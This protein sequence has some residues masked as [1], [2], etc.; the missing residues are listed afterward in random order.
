MTQPA[1][2]EAAPSTA[3]TPPT[4][5]A[6]TDTHAPLTTKALATQIREAAGVN[7]SDLRKLQRFSWLSLQGEV[8]WTWGGASPLSKDY[9]VLAM[10]DDVKEV[11]AYAAPTVPNAPYV[12]YKLNKDTPS[13]GVETMSLDVFRNAMVDELESLAEDTDVRELGRLDGREEAVEYI[14]KLAENGGLDESGAALTLA[15]IADKLEAEADLGED[16]EAE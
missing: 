12:C 5:G 2:V 15:Q 13:Y 8:A 7:M 1:Q 14:R 16:E 11:R 4:N 3:A 6:E 9:Q 10:F